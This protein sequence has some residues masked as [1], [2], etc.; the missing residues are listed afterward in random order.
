MKCSNCGEVLKDDASI[1]FACGEAVPKN[2]I[3]S[4]IDD[5]IKE[6]DEQKKKKTS[7]APKK[8]IQKIKTVKKD[9]IVKK[10]NI[11]STVKI[12]Y[13]TEV[14][15]EETK[16][17]EFGKATR[18]IAYAN[19]I[20]ITV[21][22]IS[23]MFTWFTFGGRGTFKGFESVQ[24]NSQFMTEEVKL[25][26]D[27]QIEGLDPT[28]EILKFSPKDL[29]D[30]GNLNQD[31]HKTL[32]N[33]KGE[34][35]KSFASM[36]HLIYIKGFY[37]IVGLGLLSILLL[38]VDKKLKAIEWTRGIS[39]LSIVIIG[40]NYT[41]LKIPFFSMFALKAR[42]ILRI[43]EPLS[44]VTLNMNGIN[45]NNEFYPYVL[46]EKNG[47]YVALVACVLWFIFSTVLVEMKKDKEFS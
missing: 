11:D 43:E 24:D 1:C 25:L 34:L 41:A 19:A 40:L 22:L 20:I 14:K 39:V 27:E 28:V 3:D 38:V 44:A 36:I 18:I 2:D 29:V 15:A 47:L 42:S 30:Y 37:L 35:K 12:D 6:D 4:M 31:A 7:V 17:P 45:V 8:K 33:T 13:S 23:M 5:M 10:A 16:K 21:L 46:I 32:E 26:K 9:N